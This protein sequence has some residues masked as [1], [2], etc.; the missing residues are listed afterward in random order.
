MIRV[1]VDDLASMSA[2]AI[3][4]PATIR[5]APATPA[6]ERVDRAGG[7]AFQRA[8]DLR[9]DLVVGAAVVTAAGALPVEFVIH[10]VVAVEPA[11]VT[12]K[13]LARAW[14]SVLER[15][16]EW[17]FAHIATPPLHA[18]SPELSLADI[19]GWMV[20]VVH[21]TGDPGGFPSLVSLVVDSEEDRAVLTAALR[22]S[23]ASRQ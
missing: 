17:Q 1:V 14:R 18:G 8:M 11:Q 19:A 22:L 6:A 15:A 21:D 2:D 9:D 23:Q 10:A 5:L 3:V 16:R 4:R 13:G 20:E 7:A 12:A